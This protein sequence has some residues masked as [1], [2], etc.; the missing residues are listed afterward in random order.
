[1]AGN[2]YHLGKHHSEE[3]RC[4]M[5]VTRKGKNL[6]NTFGAGNKG[7]HHTEE[8]RRKM[9]IAKLGKHP[10][11][12]AKNKMSLARTGSKHWNWQGGKSFE[13]YSTDWK[14]SLVRTIRD[15]D[16]YLC[17]ICNA[18]ENG[19]RH[20]IHHIDYN[21]KNCR[22]D[23]L[24]T[25]CGGDNNCH[26]ATNFRRSYWLDFFKWLC[27]QKEADIAQGVQ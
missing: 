2:Q 5:S 25:L 3:T 21:K 22:P 10:S 16:G 26:I 23:N 20:A 27:G 13:P 7:N 9:R 18:K 15:R 1:M 4:M 24:I 17:Q 12:E 11:E 14:G 6:G 8:A 19:R